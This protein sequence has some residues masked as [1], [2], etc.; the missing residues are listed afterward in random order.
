MIFVKIMIVKARAQILVPEIKKPVKI[1]LNDR[2]ILKC[3]EVNSRLSLTTIAK[4]V[5]LSKEVVFH[6]IK[7]LVNK[8]IIVDFYTAFNTDKFNFQ[9]YEILFKLKAIKKDERENFINYLIEHPFVSWIM[10]YGGKYDFLVEICSKNVEHFQ[11]V[12]FEI[13]NSFQEIIYDYEISMALTRYH[14]SM[15]YLDTE[16][17]S[18][19]LDFKRDKEAFSDDFNK[20]KIEKIDLDK[21][22]FEILDLLDDNARYSFAELSRKLR[23]SRDTI[24]YKIKKM[25][26]GNFIKGF[27]LR[28]NQYL[29]G[30]QAATLFL[31]L[32]VLSREE[33]EKIVD[34]LISQ[35]LINVIVKRIGQ[36]GNYSAE[37]YFRDN[38]EL[39]RLINSI[40]EEMGEKLIG[41][42]VIIQFSQ[43][44]FTYLPEGI[45]EHLKENLTN[46]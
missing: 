13:I 20:S 12:L 32:G 41:S 42:E 5:K 43:Y 38:Y 11:S 27:Q 37:I 9:R 14:S 30:F 28:L 46:N 26:G 16:K 10:G 3:L 22:D 6:R 45:L 7:N 35:P 15:K 36:H 8:G 24:K 33:E 4:K 2:K 1:D 25:I 17:I 23:I 31:R 18:L 29:L 34:F 39:D 19:N 44:K 21:K 40:K